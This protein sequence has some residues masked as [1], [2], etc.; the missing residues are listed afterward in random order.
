MCFSIDF[1]KYPD[2]VLLDIKDMSEIAFSAL[3]RIE[4]KETTL[5]ERGIVQKVYIKIFTL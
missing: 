1:L 5:S 2:I 4:L 3:S